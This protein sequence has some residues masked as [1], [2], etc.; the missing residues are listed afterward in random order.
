MPELSLAV[1]I[2]KVI[3]EWR[4]ERKVSQEEF[5]Y[6]CGVHRTYMTHLERGSN[7]PSVEV[8]ARIARGFGIEISAV[9]LELE[10]RG[11]TVLRVT[12]APTPKFE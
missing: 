2:G 11:V 8:L 10:R 9:F 4:M 6:R 1:E 12:D 5:A 7:M 3:R